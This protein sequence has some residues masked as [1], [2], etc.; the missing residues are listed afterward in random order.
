MID[1]NI[2][3][4][5]QTKI[6][7][8]HVIRL[9]MKIRFYKIWYSTDLWYYKMIRLS[10]WRIDKSAFKFYEILCNVTA[11]SISSRFAYF[12]VNFKEL[13]FMNYSL[14][15]ILTL[16]FHYS[17]DLLYPYRKHYHD[18]IRCFAWG[19][20]SPDWIIIPRSLKHTIIIHTA[21]IY[22]IRFDHL[23]AI[24]LLITFNFVPSLYVNGVGFDRSINESKISSNL[25]E[26]EETLGMH[27]PWG[28]CSHT[29]Y[30]RGGL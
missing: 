14:I 24:W 5:H 23:S 17:F 6:T 16:I 7:K 18:D 1:F 30:R 21:V 29:R 19:W 12:S 2:L 8:S 25:S 15:I 13:F 3:A 26:S 20:V 10:H 4:K 22:F 9:S 27:Y 11:G 28:S